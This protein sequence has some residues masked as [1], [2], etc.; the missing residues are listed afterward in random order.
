MG[1]QIARFGPDS[2]PHNLDGFNLEDSRYVN[3]IRKR[4]NAARTEGKLNIAALGLT[5]IPSEVLTMYD[6]PNEAGVSWYESVDVTKLAAADNEIARLP[7]SAFP[8][9]GE[10]A[11]EDD[12][13]TQSVFSF[14]ESIDLHGNKLTGIPPGLGLL[15]KLVSLNLARNKLDSSV[16]DI[17]SSLPAL[18]ELRLGENHFK[19]PLPSSVGDL[20]HL[21]VLD[22]H[23][24]GIDALPQELGRLSK[25]KRLNVA[26]NRLSTIPFEAI[27]DL[28]LIEIIASSNRLNGSL[29]P[30]NV[31]Q[32]PHLQVLDVSTNAL[33]DISE[34]KVDMPRLQ[35]LN[36]SNNRVA[37]LPDVSTWQ[38][39]VNLNVEENKISAFPEGFTHL[40]NLENADFSN[41]SLLQI[42]PAIANMHKLIQLRIVNNPIR[43]RRLMRITVTELK[44]EMQERL[45]AISQAD[46]MGRAA[47][48][49][50]S[51]PRFSAFLLGQQGAIPDLPP[52]PAWPVTAGTCDRSSRK[53]RDIE[54]K[55]LEPLV[56][57]N[58]TAL[59]LHHNWL[60]V[61]PPTISLLGASLSSL[62][63]SNNH[64]QKTV[65]YF[66]TTI[67]LPTLAT[68]NLA[69]N[70]L[71]SLAPLTTNLLAPRL[72]T[73]ILSF[74][75]LASL[76]STSLREPFPELTKVLLNNNQLTAI[77]VEAVRGLHMLDVSS[78]E[79]EALPARLALLQGTLRTLIVSGN[80]FR[81]P[82]YS[83]LNMGTEEVLNWCRMK[84]PAGEEGSLC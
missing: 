81:V 46:V 8:V 83:V 57:Q 54:S 76:P 13:A 36:I 41:N 31:I 78:N 21:Q 73:L 60:P 68:L 38:A 12:E 5:E 51:N 42:D 63:L 40:Q 16:L 1:I 64:L 7:E 25:L 77:E 53:L 28:P 37:A 44:A 58:V 50:T 55:D 10:Q 24:N 19:G 32:I 14:L 30:Q 48:P 20:V 82:G 70:A 6:T 75:R 65:E 33:I 35:T 26:D 45:N 49:T 4:V 29:F 47:S 56:E 17:L 22:L 18:A 72:S 61:V 34:H 79:I 66:Q 11:N 43:E 74:N 67:H 84:I 80:R 27:F 59:I 71:T 9:P 69:T 2:D 3:L 39:L 52:N 62:D 15:E 23:S